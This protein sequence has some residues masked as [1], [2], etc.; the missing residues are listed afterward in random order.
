MKINPITECKSTELSRNV[1]ERDAEIDLNFFFR[2]SSLRV[3]GWED[4]GNDGC[5]TLYVRSTEEGASCPYCGQY[6]EKVHSRYHRHLR[7]LPA[8][9]KEVS[10]CFEARKFFCN[11]Q[12]CRY[13]TFAE[14]PGNEMFRYRRR[15]RRC[16]VVV[17]RHGLCLSSMTTS[18]LLTNMGIPISKSTVLRDLNRLDVPECRDIRKI[19]VDDWAFRKGIDYGTIIIDLSRGIPVDLLGTR[20]GE[21]FSQWLDSHK[22]VRLVSRDR[23]TEYSHAVASSGLDI[24]EV[25]DRFHLIKNMG[26]CVTDILSAEYDRI[27]RILKGE[28]RSEES[29]AHKAGKRKGTYVNEV[30]FNEVKRLQEAG[31]GISETALLLGIARQTVRKYRD[32][33]KF[34]VPKGKPRHDYHLHQK[35]VEQ[36][37]ARGVSLDTIRQELWAKGF[38]AAKTPFHDHFSY[39]ADGHKGYR[40]AQQKAEMERKAEETSVTDNT[41][42]LPPTNHLAL[43]VNKSILGKDLTDYECEVTNALFGEEWFD[44]MY[45]AAVGFHKCLG[46]GKPAGLDKWIKKYEGS[47]IPKIKTFVKGIQMDLKAV[48]NAIL[49]PV[50]NG[51]TEGYV[52]KLKLVKRIM[53]GKAKLHLLK[54]K[55]VMAS[56]IFN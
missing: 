48:K 44:H 4:M 53:Y 45:E 20:N 37:Y 3:E 6:S 46:S 18:S 24:V 17:Y 2:G 33:D 26:D 27:T 41:I 42:P 40:P 36:Q 35:Y 50:S 11:N 21:D 30:K 14:Q 9:G 31:K 23:S 52:N 29:G 49:H 51:I 7:D 28:G 38:K 16:E 32:L 43:M 12:Q 34:P 55:M 54:V 5:V 47:S 10:I 1:K 25:A 15:T 56:W 39:L 13:R 8:L 22:G 19:G